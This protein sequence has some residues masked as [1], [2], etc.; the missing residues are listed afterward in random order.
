MSSEQKPK[1]GAAI[2]S[3]A[4]FA[5]DAEEQIDDASREEIQEMLRKQ[6]TDPDTLV[7][8]MR[9][10]I[11]RQKGEILAEELAAK[12]TDLLTMPGQMALPPLSA[13]RQAI[14]TFGYAA[15][16]TD[17]MTAEDVQALYQQVQILQT[18]NEEV[19][20]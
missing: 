18:L 16:L 5:F 6:G 19:E 8:R 14:V 20:Q 17:K 4:K 7:K 9:Q 12:R 1:S 11:G 15:R 2:N 10:F 13:M 3:L